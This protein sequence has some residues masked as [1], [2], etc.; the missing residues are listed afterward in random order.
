MTSQIK[1]ISD[2]LGNMRVNNKVLEY[3]CFG[4]NPHVAPTLVLL[5]E[6]LGCVALW[7]DFPKRLVAETHCGVFVYSRS[8]YGQSEPS[9]FP[10]PLNYMT[11]EALDVLP[12]VLNRLSIKRG[13]LLGH[14]DGASI[15]SIYAGSVN[16]P[17]VAGVILLAPHFFTEERGLKAIAETKVSYCNTSL[18]HKLAKYHRN[19]DH[20]FWGWNDSWLHPDFKSWN[21]S[22]VIDGIEAPVLAIQGKNDEY[23]TLAQ[24]NELELRISSKYSSEVLED[25]GHAPQFEKPD[26][27]LHSIRKFVGSL[28]V[29]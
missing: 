1:W 11:L 27:T 24:L 17:R 21:I 26:D 10:R 3:A 22:S 9:D 13:I 29:L 12:K 5:H 4:P 6:G 28:G 23:G 2:A 15:A 19:S 14:S 18:K 20:T 16:D 7:K 25:C 8:G